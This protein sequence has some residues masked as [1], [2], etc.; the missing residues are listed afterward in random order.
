MYVCIF[1]RKKERKKKAFTTNANSNSYMKH[2]KDAQ[3][4]AKLIKNIRVSSENSRNQ[5]THKIQNGAQSETW[6]GKKEIYAK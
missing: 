5:T 6:I 1:K 4:I 2:G 3:H